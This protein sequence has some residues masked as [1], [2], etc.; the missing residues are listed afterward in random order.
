MLH[1][2][3]IFIT[4]TLILTGIYIYYISIQIN[5][6]HLFFPKNVK[7]KRKLAKLTDT[8]ESIKSINNE[9]SLKTLQNE[10]ELPG[11]EILD[12][13]PLPPILF[14]KTHKT[15]SST[16]QNILYRLALKHDLSV[17]FPAG[18][19]ANNFYWPNPFKT[20]YLQNDIRSVDIFAN[21]AVFSKE[22]LKCFPRKHK[23]PDSS[24]KGNVFMF[25][26]LREPSSLFKSTFNYFKTKVEG[27]R[28]ANSMEEFLSDPK[29][30]FTT[31][32]AK[33][34]NHPNLWPLARNHLIIFW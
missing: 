17:A 6:T 11:T 4:I 22:I 12:S 14:I 27:F 8:I 31:E 26:I 28:E 33:D 29:R 19:M 16:V 25:T 2:R 15:G 1:N 23:I 20:D 3:P 24:N 30:Y 21:H 18:T 13:Y 9:T 34:V 7:S 5:N 32:P 10:T